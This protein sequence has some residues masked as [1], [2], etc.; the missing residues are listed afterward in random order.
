[1]QDDA[2]GGANMICWCGGTL[3]L[4]CYH[5]KQENQEDEEV[6]CTPDINK[7]DIMDITDISDLTDVPNVSIADIA[8]L[9]NMTI[10]N[11]NIITDEVT[12]EM[13]I[14][15]N[16][17]E[18]PEDPTDPTKTQHLVLHQHEA[19]KIQEPKNQEFVT[20]VFNHNQ[21]ENRRNDTPTS[22]LDSYPVN[23]HNKGTRVSTNLDDIH[24]EATP[25]KVDP[26]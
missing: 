26:R 14:H 15:E 3:H 5:R 1:M 2:I 9:T 7:E 18:D 4:L 16:I 17:H 23:S 22:H 19:V 6:I 10:S 11:I 21:R 13:H 20:S 8:S 25:A 12:K 24:T